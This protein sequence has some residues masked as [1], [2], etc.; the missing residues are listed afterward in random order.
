[1]SETPT[2]PDPEKKPSLADLFFKMHSG[3]ASED[4]LKIIREA[5][6]DPNS[7][8][9]KEIAAWNDKERE[10]FMKKIGKYRDGG[11]VRL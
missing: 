4:E 1:M 7:E 5:I 11:D 8:M 10:E 3:E 9:N 6:E 2:V